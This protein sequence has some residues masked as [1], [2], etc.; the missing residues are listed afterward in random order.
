MIERTLAGGEQRWPWLFVGYF[1][2]QALW[3]RLIG[4]ALGL[5][6]A[7]IMLDGRSLAWGYGPQPPLYGWL[8]WGFFR[9]IPDPLLAMALLKD[10]LLAG[11][12]LA[13]Y[14]LLRSAHPPRVAGLA[15]ASMLL[16]PQVAWESQRALTH[17]VLVT[18]IAAGAVLVFWT[19]VL[20]ARRG[21]DA[22]FGALLGLGLLS[23]ANFLVL[24]LALW[25]TAWGTREL[26]PRL[27]P[28][29]VAVAVAVA[30][31]IAVGPAFWALQHP[32]IAL[33]SAFKLRRAPDQAM[34]VVAARGLGA[35]AA[36][37][38][39]F[40]ALPAAVLAG[41]RW[42]FGVAGAAPPPRG[43]LERFLMRAMLVALALTALAVL[44][45]GATAAKGRWLQPMLFLAPP[46]ATLWLL[47]RVS[48]AGARWLERAIVT[49]A[50]LATLALP[51][52][53]LTGLPGDPA[54]GGAPVE[55]L[56]RELPAGGRVLAD[57]EWLAGNLAYRR[58]AWSVERARGAALGSREAA[59]L[60]WAEERSRDAGT[61]AELAAGI[62]AR[63]G[64]S[65]RLEEARRIV[66]PY[67]WQPD[68]SFVA[69]IAPLVAAP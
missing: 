37:V 43:A 69:F 67:P 66:L 32:D 54:R 27:R 51:V 10:A 56:V 13:V 22:G 49:V 7:Q 15:S 21:A 4:G 46:L 18:A 40:L 25:L 61:G 62:A 3:R 41:L 2:F 23:K 35:L 64:R 36:A 29:G 5:D 53:L 42:R 45:S 59:V 60:V 44:G 9:L 28:A 19:R 11:T 6:E 16:L 31:A 33:S 14:A 57:P 34:P 58:P 50:V 1:A 12:F 20:E 8:Q 68:A 39:G 63:S 24:P 30:A 65:V 52:A 55:A 47:P 48:T 17:S 26:R 38:I